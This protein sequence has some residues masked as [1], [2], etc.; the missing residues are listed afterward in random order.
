MSRPAPASAYN[1]S[2]A[3]RLHY[4]WQVPGDHTETA[5]D[6]A[7]ISPS[8]GIGYTRLYNN[9]WAECFHIHF[10]QFPESPDIFLQTWEPPP[11]LTFEI[12]GSHF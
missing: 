11:D 8:S 7:Y 3:V 6:S 10:W 5:D 12:S 4:S 2:G 1:S 9:H